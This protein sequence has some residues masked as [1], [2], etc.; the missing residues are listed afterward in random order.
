MVRSAVLEEG[1]W[2]GDSMR[3]HAAPTAGFEAAVRCEGVWKRGLGLQV[4]HAPLEFGDG[5]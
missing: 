5:V 3:A 2:G 4:G 1:W